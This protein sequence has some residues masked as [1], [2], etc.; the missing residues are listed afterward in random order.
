MRS[1]FIAP[2]VPFSTASCPF[3]IALPASTLLRAG[4][5]LGGGLGFLERLHG[6]RILLNAAYVGAQERWKTPHSPAR[7]GIVAPND[8]L[9]LDNA[10]TA[11]G[12][13]LASLRH[14]R[15]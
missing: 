12:Q 14:E 6:W 2:L 10:E 1:L 3:R 5:P 15:V 9:T 4:K 11:Q 7:D 13:Q 8:R